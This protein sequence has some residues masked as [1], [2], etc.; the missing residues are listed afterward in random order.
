MVIKWQ[1]ALV[2]LRVGCEINILLFVTLCWNIF[3]KNSWIQATSENQ[4]SDK[5]FGANF[6]ALAVYL[7]IV[8]SSFSLWVFLTVSEEL[9]CI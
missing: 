6:S 5:E 4:E 9:W 8:H 2:I 1:T 7:S 3:A